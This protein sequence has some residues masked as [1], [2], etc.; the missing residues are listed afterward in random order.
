VIVTRRADLYPGQR[1]AVEALLAARPHAIVVSAREP[2]DAALFEGAGALACIYGDQ[3]VSFEGLAE[4][5][6]PRVR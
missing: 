3:A 2:Y 1:A 4:V 5:M 6:V